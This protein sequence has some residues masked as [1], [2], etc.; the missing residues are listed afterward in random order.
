MGRNQDQEEN[1]LD[2]DK[3]PKANEKEEDVFDKVEVL[4]IFSR[5][6]C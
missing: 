2:Q 5:I 1:V 4:F 6:Y 3:V